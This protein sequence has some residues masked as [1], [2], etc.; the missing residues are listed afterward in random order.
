MTIPRHNVGVFVLGTPTSPRALKKHAE[1]W[2]SY[3]SG[4]M[5]HHGE[6][7]EAYLS[8]FV[9]GVEMRTY[10]ASNRN[11]VAGYFGPCWA[12]WLVLDIDRV[13]LET[14]LADTRRLV[15]FLMRRYPGLGEPPAFFSGSKGAHI[16]VDLA[17]NPPPAVGFHESCKALALALA[18][19]AGVAI[20]PSIYDLAH[21][22]RL[23]NSR[24]PKT[25]LFKRFV[26]VD[27]LLQLSADRIRE[28]ARHPAE[29][30]SPSTPRPDP[31][32]AIDWAEAEAATRRK[33]EARAAIRRDAGPDARAPRWFL[34]LLRFGVEEG[35]RHHTVFRAAAWLTEQSA[36]PSL[37]RA[38][39]TEP[40]CDLGLTPGDTARQIDCGIRHAQ[41]QRGPAPDP[42]TDPAPDPATDPAAFESWAIRHEA[43]PLPPGARDFPP[44]ASR[45]GLVAAIAERFGPVSD[46]VYSPPL[47]EADGGQAS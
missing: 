23:P 1:L 32:L 28:L 25:G 19:N 8:H 24:H 20:D 36:S 12:R 3:A 18:A 40:A 17:H 45:P 22:I 2:D 39:L 7:R 21:I 41:K 33:T 29:F 14:A 34:D 9:F 5:A 6:D 43:D 44:A 42:A 10:Y 11:S 15:G 13:D 16:L 4:A 46:V 47:T 37:V 38:L 27:E 31:Q 26:G 30:V 35:Q